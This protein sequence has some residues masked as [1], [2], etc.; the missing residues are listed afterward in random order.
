MDHKGNIA[1]L[2]WRGIN[3][4]ESVDGAARA[5]LLHSVLSQTPDII[6]LIQEHLPSITLLP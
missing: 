6:G 1:E 5:R 2:L 3:D 4:V